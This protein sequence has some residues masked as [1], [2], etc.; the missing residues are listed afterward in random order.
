M[1][2]SLKGEIVSLGLGLL[3][4]LT[5]YSCFDHAIAKAGP[6]EG[7]PCYDAAVVADEGTAVDCAPGM[8]VEFGGMSEG[9][10]TIICHCPSSP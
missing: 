10:A 3:V 4:A 9:I 8:R 7:E 1:T 5:V 6:S 2:V